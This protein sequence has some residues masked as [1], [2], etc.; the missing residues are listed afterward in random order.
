MARKPAH[1][2]LAGGKGLRQLLWERIHALEGGEFTLNEIVFGGES[3]DTARDY[4]L[5]LER[6]TYLAVTQDSPPGKRRAKRWKLVRDNGAEAPRLRRDGGPVT[7]GLAQ[8]Q[9]W[10]TLRTLKGDTNAR[11]LSAYASTEH[12]PVSEVAAKDYLLHL[13]LASYLQRTAEGKGRGKGGTQARYRLISNT[14][15]RPPMVQRTDA[16]YDPNLGA[17]VWIKP[18]NEETAFYGQ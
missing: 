2:E 16:M 9:M 12:I 3:I 1:L 8:E 17:V 11:E 10:R 4:I 15:P 14:G 18:V 6:A 5:A 7:M 13:F